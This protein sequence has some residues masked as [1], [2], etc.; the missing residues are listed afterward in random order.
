MRQIF[1]LTLSGVLAFSATAGATVTIDVGD[2]DHIVYLAPDLA[3]QSIPLYATTDASDQVTGLV[4]R[5]QIGDGPG[6]DPEPVFDAVT[7]FGNGS[8]WET[9]AYGVTDQ[10]LYPGPYNQDDVAFN[11]KGDSVPADGSIARLKFST[12]GF[13]T[14]GS[15]YDLKFTETNPEIGGPTYFIPLDF[16]T[17]EKIWPDIVNGSIT[18]SYPGDASLDGRV[19]VGDLG[20]LAAN[21]NQPGGYQQ[22]DF[23]RD[24]HV[25]VGDLGILA[26]N[27]GNDLGGG[28]GGGSAVQLVPEPGAGLMCLVGGLL[29]LVLGRQRFALGR[30]R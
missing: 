7:D 24:G 1:L 8:I 19:S 10:G 28:G 15:S 18:I 26:A 21:W 25:Y 16:P 17:N 6:G 2:D 30:R 29:L 5:G 13:S 9:F 3:G 23:S 22:G 14:T 27:W 4:L 20:I 12:V 11:T